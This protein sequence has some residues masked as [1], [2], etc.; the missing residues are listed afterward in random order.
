MQELARAGARGAISAQLG[1]VLEG[2]APEAVDAL[3]EETREVF[4]AGGDELFRE[5]DPG[6][7][8]YLIL[9]GRLRA[10]RR[11]G[12]GGERVLQEMG[13]GEFVGEMPLVRPGA[14]AATVRAVRDSHLGALAP[15]GFARVTE[16]HPEVLRRVA[17]LL[18][19]RLR[20]Q[21]EGA[22]LARAPLR[23]VAVAPA[24]PGAPVG[25]LAAGLELA[26][27]RL[28]GVRRIDAAGFA[29]ARREL[30]LLGDAG[31]QEPRNAAWLAE[32]ESA[33][34]VL[35]YEGDP[36]AGAWTQRCLRQ[37]DHAV[38]VAPEAPG[39][40]PWLER[41]LAE[42]RCAARSLVAIEGRPTLPTRASF[43]FALTL[44]APPDFDRLAR[45]LTG[46]AV[47]VVLGG[48]GAR[49]LAHLGVLRALEE[50]G[51]PVDAI[52]GTSAGAVVGALVARGLDAASVQEICRR[53]FRS[54]FDPTFPIVAML[55]GRRIASRL[56]A[57]VGNRS[58]EGLAIPFL[59][60]STNLSRGAVR[61]HRSGPLL[62]AVR[63]SLA[64]PGILPPVVEDGELL[65]DGA[66]L[67]N[68]PVLAMR[69]LTGGGPVVAVDVGAGFSSSPYPDLP[70]ELSGWSALRRRFGRSSPGGSVPS[71]FDILM[72]SAM[73]S[74]IGAAGRAALREGI[75]LGITP[76][77]QDFGLFA[78]D[79]V[80]EI[81]ER[82]YR[83][84]KEPV[85]AWW[86]G[87][88]ASCGGR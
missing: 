72:R 37:A 44:R 49:G 80:D 28:G 43:R 87:M 63:A 55:R 64:I 65:V 79:R 67:D 73:V 22:A 18:V 20:A 41:A 36:D 8:A 25:A 30:P 35:V 74:S 59:S 81:A 34:G 9:S 52:G 48:G 17:S 12:A 23:T 10:L 6:D 56:A 24:G 71:I 83:A 11:D 27:G 68:L 13:P 77:V 21:A 32:Q 69:E 88:R 7:T 50:I 75:D 51:V 54:V 33:G 46:R 84:A 39:D 19:D 61:V 66:L 2:L 58:I 14:R 42:S 16:R 26:L 78:F 40:A 47:G 60:V 5:G 45:L 82:G 70:N 31:A 62:R 4:L 86:E 38:W 29:Q 85:R 53:H 3:A 15:E 1:R 57:V 76:P